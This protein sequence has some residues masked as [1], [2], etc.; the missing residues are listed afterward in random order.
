MKPN[1]KCFRLLPI[2]VWYYGSAYGSLII[3]I[4]FF[5]LISKYF[6]KRNQKGTQ[7]VYKLQTKRIKYEKSK[8]QAYRT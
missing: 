6:N 8:Y 4:F 1:R 5:F 7:E 3:G 2:L